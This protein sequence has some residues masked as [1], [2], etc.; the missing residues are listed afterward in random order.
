MIEIILA[1]PGPLSS[2]AELTGVGSKHVQAAGSMSLVW[3]ISCVYYFSTSL[4]MKSH[5][6]IHFMLVKQSPSPFHKARLQK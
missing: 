1:Q 3:A 2:E 6:K 4:M 5:H